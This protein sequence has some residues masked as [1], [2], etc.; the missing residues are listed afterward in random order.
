M[1]VHSCIYVFRGQRTICRSRSLHLRC[2]FQELGWLEGK[3][4]DPL[5]HLTDPNNYVS[6]VLGLELTDLLMLGKCSIRA[7]LQPQ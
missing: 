2:E 5:S 7:T 3:C 4:P 6:S 1:C